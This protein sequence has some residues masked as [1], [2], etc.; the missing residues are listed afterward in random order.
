LAAFAVT[1]ID[2]LGGTNQIIR[3]AGL[4]TRGF[5]DS[6]RLSVLHLISWVALVDCQTAK[7]VSV[8]NLALSQ[9]GRQT[10][11]ASPITPVPIEI[12]RTPLDH[13]TEA[14]VVA[15]KSTLAELP[16]NAWKPTIHAIFGK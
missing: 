15:I 5:D 14:Q 13:L 6:T 1:S 2:F 16:A 10:L 7:P 9:D 12:S 8:K 3:G 11:R 4:Y